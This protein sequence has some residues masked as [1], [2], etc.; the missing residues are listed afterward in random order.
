MK[1][2]LMTLV[3]AIMAVPAM[4]QEHSHE[5]DGGEWLKPVKA[6]FICMVNNQSYDTPQISVEVEGKTYYGCC[7]M[8][9][10]RLAN[11]PAV[12]SAVDP[13]SG[14]TVNKADAVI[15]SGPDRT[16]YYFENEENFQ[17]YA[18]SPMPEMKH[19]HMKGM[20]MHSKDKAAKE[21][22]ESHESHH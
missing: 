12:R 7:P 9:K 22:P 1:K 14:N 21:T 6:Q 18:S 13:V 16:V 4:A 10:D 15:G 3:L 11:D 20:D 5:H 17:K 8:C 19:D 2:L